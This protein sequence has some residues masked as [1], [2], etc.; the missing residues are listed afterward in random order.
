M[1]WVEL[2]GPNFVSGVLWGCWRLR[3]DGVCGNLTMCLGCNS[4][5]SL[6]PSRF[7]SKTSR[8]FFTRGLI[9]CVFPDVNFRVW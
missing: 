6:M 2:A 4:T 9:S 1:S 3:G 7:W 5:V 8:E